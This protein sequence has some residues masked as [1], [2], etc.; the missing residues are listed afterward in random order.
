MGIELGSESAEFIAQR[1]MTVNQNRFVKCITEIV[2]L[3]ENTIQ[4][5]FL[6]PVLLNKNV[7]RLVTVVTMKYATMGSVPLNAKTTRIVKPDKIVTMM[8][9]A[10]M[11]IPNA[12]MIMIVVTLN[13]VTMESV[14]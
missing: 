5:V 1:M 13:H 10:W 14:W 7:E 3:L 2:I 9:F 4:I 6:E 12:K 8:E 11:G